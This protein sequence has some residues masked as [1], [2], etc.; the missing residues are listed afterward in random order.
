MLLKNETN[1]A[2]IWPIQNKDIH[3]LNTFRK[4][5]FF[6]NINTH[7][8]TYTQT[9]LNKYIHIYKFRNLGINGELKESP[10]CFLKDWC[11]I[12]IDNGTQ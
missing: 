10:R 6:A 3:K 4:E 1:I 12:V 8:N 11:Q 5:T 7:M 9:C 2:L